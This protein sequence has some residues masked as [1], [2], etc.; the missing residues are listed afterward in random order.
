MKLA[1]FGGVI[2]KGISLHLTGAELVVHLMKRT[3]YH[4]NRKEA[5]QTKLNELEALVKSG[6]EESK[7]VGKSSSDNSPTE[8][9]KR[10]VK[11][12]E[13]KEKF[14]DFASKHIVTDMGYETTISDLITYEIAPEGIRQY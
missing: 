11:E 3:E 6:D 7:S 4:K 10:S 5:Y 1:D 12:H 9:L 8:A 13:R 14:F 2:H